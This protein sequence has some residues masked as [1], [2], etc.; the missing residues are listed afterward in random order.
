MRHLGWLLIA[1]AVTAPGCGPSV[2]Q[3]RIE[4]KAPSASSPLAEATSLLQRYA[5]GQPLTSEATSF[6]ALVE[7]V[8]KEDPAKADILQ[9]GFADLQK[10][11][12]AARPAKAKEILAKLRGGAK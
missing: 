6:P 9:A 1:L 12:A 8:R 11:T 7:R 4:I 2:K 3:E 10:A 5:D